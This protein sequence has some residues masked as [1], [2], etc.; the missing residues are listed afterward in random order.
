MRSRACHRLIS[1]EDK[2]L[3]AL[4]KSTQ[5]ASPYC[6]PDPEVARKKR[7]SPKLATLKQRT[8]SSVFSSALRGGQKGRYAVR[9]RK[10]K[11][12]KDK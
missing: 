5:K 1:P 3:L 12:N 7:R 6:P 9:Y 2:S 11:F 10:I 4:S 8:A